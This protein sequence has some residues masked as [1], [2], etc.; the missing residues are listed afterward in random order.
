MIPDASIIDN[1]IVRKSTLYRLVYCKTFSYQHV[2]M[3]Q[4]SVMYSAK[5]KI[6]EDLSEFFFVVY[7]IMY[8]TIIYFRI[9][10]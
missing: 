3:S 9:R 8:N 5:G 7:I 4:L 1:V 2:K 10:F 6:L